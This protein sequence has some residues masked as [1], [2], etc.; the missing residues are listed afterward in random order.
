MENKQTNKEPT[1]S[2]VLSAI[3]DYSTKTDQKISELSLNTQEMRSDMQE[4]CSDMKEM[5]A[6][7]K[8]IDAIM[9]TKEYL[10]DKLADLRG[11]LTI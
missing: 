10:D 7:I 1:I 9:V 2:E 11:D 4:M 3:N 8:R 6:D 5:R